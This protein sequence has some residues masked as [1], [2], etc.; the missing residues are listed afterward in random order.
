MTYTTI[1]IRFVA[2]IVLAAAVASA[3]SYTAGK[4]AVIDAGGIT[5]AV[6]VTR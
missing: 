3:Y 1:T 4:L 5:A 2:L 6:T